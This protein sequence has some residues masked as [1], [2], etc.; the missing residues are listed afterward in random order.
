MNVNRRSVFLSKSKFLAG[1]QCLRYLWVQAN[2]PARLPPVDTRTQF[3]FDQG[4]EVGELAKRLYPDGIDVSDERFAVNLRR[5]RELLTGHRTLFEA[6]FM[7]GGLYARVDILRPAG[8][9]AWGIIEV[10]STTEVKD[11]HL[12]DLAFQKH[13][14]QLAGLA[15]NGCYLAHV[16]KEFVKSG[17]VV[18]S[19]FFVVERVTEEVRLLSPKVEER[20]RE[21]SRRSE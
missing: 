20:A 9:G 2:D 13:C 5:T 14:C 3:V 17:D 12:P 1:L 15:I 11:V 4:H 21:M 18:P 7:V 6:G 16:N 19:E 10:K 8:G